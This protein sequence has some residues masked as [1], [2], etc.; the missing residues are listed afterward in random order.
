MN[1][2][3]CYIGISDFFICMSQR[4]R[5]N[6]FWNLFRNE[7]AHNILRTFNIEY[8]TVVPAIYDPAV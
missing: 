4:R 5:E 2:C 1:T 6:L 8:C 7:N 3:I